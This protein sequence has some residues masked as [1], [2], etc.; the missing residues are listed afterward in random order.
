[1]TNRETRRCTWRASNSTY[2]KKCA[3]KK[4]STDFMRATTPSSLCTE[5]LICQP[6]PSQLLPLSLQEQSAAENIHFL[7]DGLET[8]YRNK[9]M[10]YVLACKISEMCPIS[11]VGLHITMK[12]PKV[13]VRLRCGS[14]CRGTVDS[15]EVSRHNVLHLTP[16]CGDIQDRYPH[17]KLFTI[18]GYEIEKMEALISKEKSN[19]LRFNRT[20]KVHQ[21]Q[22][23][24]YVPKH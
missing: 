22:G 15:I 11:S 19:L 24:A 6:S 12:L 23:N 2:K 4:A 1:M 14:P 5:D 13:R 18:T 8:N 17:I 21:L 7:S 16:F 9:L 3:A 10:F 20:L